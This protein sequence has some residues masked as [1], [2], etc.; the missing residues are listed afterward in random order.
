MYFIAALATL[1]H[2][3]ELLTPSFQFSGVVSQTTNCCHFMCNCKKNQK[4]KYT[5]NSDWKREGVEMP[6]PTVCTHC[7]FKTSRLPAP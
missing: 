3:D 5:F 6:G 1:V 2:V 4:C 7:L